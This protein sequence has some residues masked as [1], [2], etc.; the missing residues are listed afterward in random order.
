M[1]QFA[2]RERLLRHML[3]TSALQG[4]ALVVSAGALGQPGS[5][6]LEIRQRDSGEAVVAA[7][8]ICAG[9]VVA[10]ADSTG[11]ASGVTCP[12]PVRV[13]ADGYMPLVVTLDAVD[14]RVLLVPE[15]AGLQEVV[16]VLAPVLATQ[17]VGIPAQFVLQATELAALRSPLLDD[18][19]RAMQ[20]LPGVA[21]SDDL[22]AE[23]S[24]RG[25]PF[26]QVGVVL[27][28]VKSRLLM[29]TV[30]G[31]EQTGSVALLNGDMVA[32]GAL[33]AGS[34]PQRYGNSLGAEL[35]VHTRDGRS[36]R[37]RGRLLTSAIATTATLEGPAGTDRV[38]WIA[39]VR[40]S[41]ASWITTRID[42][43]LSGTFD[44]QD[45]QGRVSA[46]LG[47]GHVVSLSLLTGTSAYDER[48]RRTAAFAIDVG[49]N[50][51]HLASARWQGTVSPTLLVSQRLTYISSRFRNENPVSRV[52]DR[53]DERETLYRAAITWAPAPEVS[54][55]A[56]VLVEGFRVDGMSV[57]FGGTAGPDGADRA[58]GGRTQ[59]R[60]SHVHVRWTP[61][62]AVRVGAGGRVDTVDGL[63]SAVSPWIQAEAGLS[64]HW[65]LQIAT[66]QHAQAPDLLQRAGPFPAHALTYE[67]A[68]HLDVGIGWRRG[69]WS[70]QLAAYR[71][72]EKDVLDR[73]DAEPRRVGAS[74]VPGNPVA[75]WMNTLT[76]R[77]RGIEAVVRQ[78][79]ARWSGW[80]SYAYGRTQL[81]SADEVA[82]AGAF[83]QRH[84]TSAAISARLAPRWDGSITI[85]TSSNWPYAGYYVRPV[86][87]R[88]F[89]WTQRN[90]LRLPLYSRVDLRV[91]RMVA[92]PRGQLTLFGEAINVFN[93]RNL[94]QAAET[95]NLATT[96]VRG[97]SEKQLPIIPSVGVS[98]EF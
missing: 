69:G 74:V 92:L 34:Y 47:G 40:R 37:V 1:L 16:T 88:V 85:R 58:F 36:D 56:S 9:V 54:F 87:D 90:T 18:P 95:V 78:G 35:V 75:P 57:L 14:I 25:S 27:D 32:A 66:G 94:R 30:R 24:V 2:P 8:V 46:H 28:D 3:V 43:D 70:A 72:D 29:H 84:V 62:D 6:T 12:A 33:A 97:L 98:W 10:T 26:R 7:R 83:D 68:R 67:R 77:S 60:G 81:E 39:A 20:A 82:F 53:G 73:P 42:P 64:R 61:L 45:A 52:L 79:S 76:G 48:G 65:F 55:D 89:L 51:T 71:R 19:L 22:R 44:F 5:S 21:T 91:R 15:P 86:D 96:E 31:V 93:R 50:R 4:V 13:E 23:F 41:Y 59:R 80:V 17:D 49:R 38:T 11:R 63:G